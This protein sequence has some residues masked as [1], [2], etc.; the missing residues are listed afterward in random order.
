[1]SRPGQREVFDFQK[2]LARSPVFAQ[3]D[4]LDFPADHLMGDLAGR[5]LA[6]VE[7][8]DQPPIPQ[9]G[10]PLG[11]PKHLL[12]FVRDIKDRHA[13]FSQPT[14]HAKQPLDFAFG[15]GAGRFIHDEDL[16]PDRKGLGD[17]HQLLI[18]HP[19]FPHQL[20][21]RDGA[22]KLLKNRRRLPLH[23]AVVQEAPAV[24][25]FPAQEDVRRRRQFFNEI[26][27]L[28][29]NAY[30]RGLGVA[31]A[32][33]LRRLPLEQN[34]PLRS[35]EHPGENFHQRTFPRPILPHHRM[36]FAGQNIKTHIL[37]SRHAGEPL[38]DMLNGDDGGIGHKMGAC[39]SMAF[40]G[41]SNA[42]PAS[43][44]SVCFRE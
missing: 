17:F 9:H 28:M 13:L 1:M 37:Q 4:F 25:A 43:V 18:A 42:N 15:E 7:R 5:G 10:D 12:H 33:K 8:A 21:G 44:Q 19:Q 14:D 31:G 16:R 29:D 23:H 35:R 27:F 22:F 39:H 41:L 3:V 34:P 26:E 20:R 30:T 6:F 24:G 2:T 32:L 36:Q 38:G 11:Q 40:N